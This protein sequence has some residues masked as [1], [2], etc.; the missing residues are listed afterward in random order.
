[1]HLHAIGST[2]QRFGRVGASEVASEPPSGRPDNSLFILE[3][4]G[5]IFCVPAQA[6]TVHLR[7]DVEMYLHTFSYPLANYHERGSQ[8][9]SP[10]AA[11]N[12]SVHIV[13]GRLPRAVV[14]VV[15]TGRAPRRPGSLS[16]RQ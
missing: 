4:I 9:L 1:M 5:R 2:A 11:M 3:I 8:K 13:R 16:L 12:V 7:M 10:A 6:C 14:P 15:P